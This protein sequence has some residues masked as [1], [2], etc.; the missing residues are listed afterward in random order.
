[1]Q[2]TAKKVRTSDFI[3]LLAKH[4]SK[5]RLIPTLLPVRKRSDKSGQSICQV[6]SLIETAELAI[7]SATM[8]PARRSVGTTAP[9]ESL[10]NLLLDFPSAN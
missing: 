6:I 1:V 7:I 9:L 8:R 2:I 10:I 3:W 4:K 5:E